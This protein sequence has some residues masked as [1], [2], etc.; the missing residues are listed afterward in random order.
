[1]VFFFFAWVDLFH[2][3]LCWGGRERRASWW[4]DAPL[5]IQ[6]G[7]Q[8]ASHDHLFPLLVLSV[9]PRHRARRGEKKKN[10]KRSR[11]ASQEKKALL[12]SDH[13]RRSRKMKAAAA[14]PLLLLVLVAA[15]SLPDGLCV[16]HPQDG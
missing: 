5:A 13:S 2:A 10:L 8:V 12:N 3:Q 7:L 6:R 11:P 15:A 1:M 16:T 9:S 14:A 4:F